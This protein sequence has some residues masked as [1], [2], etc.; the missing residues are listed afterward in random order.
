MIHQG[1]KCQEQKPRPSQPWLPVTASNDRHR[2][3][4]FL[5]FALLCAIA[6][7]VNKGKGKADG[8]FPLWEQ[9]TA[10]WFTH[11]LTSSH[12]KELTSQHG[13]A[14]CFAFL[15]DWSH[16]M[17]MLHCSASSSLMEKL[18]HTLTNADWHTFNTRPGKNS[19]R[20][21]LKSWF[22]PSATQPVS[23]SLMSN[24]TWV[25]CHKVLQQRLWGSGSHKTELLYLNNI[26]LVQCGPQCSEQW[27]YKRCWVKEVRYKTQMLP[28]MKRDKEISHWKSQ[29]H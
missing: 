26:G 6:E 12:F 29:R 3:N 11:C 13:S 17:L 21:G 20:V 5:L 16:L 9:Q 23:D 22:S 25:V 18:S 15:A 28:E 10:L 7:A 1:R 4:F 14:V 27:S 24:L 2:L 8:N 19:Y